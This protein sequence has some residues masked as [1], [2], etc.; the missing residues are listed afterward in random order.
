MQSI[1][2]R[3]PGRTLSGY[4]HDLTVS[5]LRIRNAVNWRL[6]GAFAVNLV[7]WG[8]LATLLWRLL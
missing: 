3:A 5:P 7:L 4:R 6:V 1:Q 8:G 2:L